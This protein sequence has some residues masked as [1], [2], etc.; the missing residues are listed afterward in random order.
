MKR[1][2]ELA[3]ILRAKIEDYKQKG[4]I[5]KLTSE[6]LQ[7]RQERIWYLP[8]FPVFNANKPGKV[9]VVWDAAAKTNGVSLNSVLLKGPDLLTPLDYVLYRFRE[10]RIGLSGDVREM[11]LQML[12]TKKDQH[13]LRILWCDDSSGDPS[14]YVTQVMPF[15]TSCSPSCAQYVKNLNASKYEDQFPAAA[16]AISKQHYVDDM[17]VSVETEEEA[18]QLA[19]DVKYVHAQAGFDMRNWISNSSAVVEAM[20]NETSH[21]KNLNIGAELGTEKVLGMWWCTATDTFTYKLSSKHDPTLLEGLRKPTK[22]EILR[23]LMAVF[24]PLGL[25]SDVLIY[26]KVLFQEVWRSGIG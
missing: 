20:A 2:P 25:I 21:E 8:L 3:A 19:K 5:R 9:R 14:T 18:I 1:E 11:Y 10:F 15:G 13:C 24:D 16:E 6:E 4:Y 23:T 7:A 12:M 17:L 26:L 22:R